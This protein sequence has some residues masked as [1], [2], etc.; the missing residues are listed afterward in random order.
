MY[1]CCVHDIP[2]A[3]TFQLMASV[4]VGYIISFDTLVYRPIHEKEHK[5]K[6]KDYCLV[7]QEFS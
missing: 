7:L 3:I 4:N 6:Y 5:G 1:S 2:M